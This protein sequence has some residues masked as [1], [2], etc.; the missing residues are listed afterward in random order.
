MIHERTDYKREGIPVERRE[1]EDH[2]VMLV[3][4]RTGKKRLG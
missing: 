1:V 2:G 3:R 4:M